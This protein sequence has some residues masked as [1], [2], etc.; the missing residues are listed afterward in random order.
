MHD[1]AAT[2]AASVDIALPPLVHDR[3]KPARYSIWK[4][5]LIAGGAAIAIYPTIAKAIPHGTEIAYFVIGASSLIGIVVGV[6][7]HHPVRSAPW[8]LLAA[9]M[10]LW[11]IGDGI[12]NTSLFFNVSEFELDLSSHLQD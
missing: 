5:W 4:W 6:H 3:P 9:G 7:M 10:T 8:Y 2:E 1:L 11:V 12:Y